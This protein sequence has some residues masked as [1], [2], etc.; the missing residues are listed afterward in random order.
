[1]IAIHPVAG[2]VPA[3]VRWQMP[4]G[5]LPVRGPAVE[6]PAPLHALLEQGAVEFVVVGD[7]HVEITLTEGRDWSREGPTVR[8][9]LLA[10]LEAPGEWRTGADVDSVDAAKG[11]VANASL[12]GSGWTASDD[13]A[14]RAAAE[15]MVAGNLD[16]VAI[17]L[18][19]QRASLLKRCPA[20]GTLAFSFRSQCRP[21]QDTKPLSDSDFANVWTR[22][23]HCSHGGVHY[24]TSACQ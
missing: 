22:C 21:P 3:T 8:S 7:D 15:V 10:A 16:G 2:P 24:L 20:H 12:P 4:A 5:T 19:Q 1:M 17:D 13:E 9:A 6:L 18:E 11:E 14:L 23:V